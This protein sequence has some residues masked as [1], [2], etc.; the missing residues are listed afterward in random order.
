MSEHQKLSPFQNAILGSISAVLALTITYPLDIVKTRLQANKALKSLKTKTASEE[1]KFILENEGGIKGLYSGLAS[2]LIGVSSQNFS[3]FF[4]HNLI[5]GK[6]LEERGADNAEVGIL[7][8]LFL[9]SLA[10]CVSQLFTIPVSVITTRQQTESMNLNI[11]QVAGEIIKEDGFQGLWKGIG[12]S[13]ILTINPAITYGVY[14]R[15]KSILDKR[16]NSSSSLTTFFLGIFSK[17][18]ATIVTYPYI[19]AKVR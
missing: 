19:M 14:E 6:Y 2:A 12:P 7:M 1:I 11:S 10:G 16:N 9:G 13:T 8:E 15:V 17:T 3:Y 18:L 4:W 5:R